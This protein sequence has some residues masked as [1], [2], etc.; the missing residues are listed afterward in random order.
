MVDDQTMGIIR[1]LFIFGI[2]IV[3]LG[4]G[5]TLDGASQAILVIIGLA[6]IFGGAIVFYKAVKWQISPFYSY[7]IHKN[8]MISS[9]ESQKWTIL[10][11]FGKDIMIHENVSLSCV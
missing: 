3:F 4:V 10:Y 2:G 5:S 8:S 11:Y 7:E 1:G 9:I 6:T